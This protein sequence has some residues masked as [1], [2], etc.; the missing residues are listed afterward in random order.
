MIEKE[1]V[2]ICKCGGEHQWS[3]RHQRN[4][5]SKDLAK[6]KALYGEFKLK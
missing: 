3:P 6:Y 2:V 1:G 5:C 4:F